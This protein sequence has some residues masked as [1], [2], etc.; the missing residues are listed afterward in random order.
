[1]ERFVQTLVT[2]VEAN[3][4]F[5]MGRLVVQCVLVIAAGVGLWKLSGWMW[6]LCLL[7]FLFLAFGAFIVG[8]QLKL[9]LTMKLEPP[10]RAIGLQPPQTRS[11]EQVLEL[12]L[13]QGGITLVAVRADLVEGVLSAARE[14]GLE[15]VTETEALKAL[16][17]ASKRIERLHDIE[18]LLPFVPTP[19]LRDE[20]SA[21]LPRASD[22]L[23]R[24][25]QILL[26]AEKDAQSTTSLRSPK[27]VFEK[28]LRAKLGQL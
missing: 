14:A 9:H 25:I 11:R 13:L 28:E 26:M 6:W 8:F 21:A 3:Q 4:R 23:L 5:L 10:W 24:E 20:I 17:G 27:P 7:L 16:A 18:V 15:V 12:H 22:E 2:V 1:M 19:E